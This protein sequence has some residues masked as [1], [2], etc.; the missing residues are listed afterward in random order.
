MGST[1]RTAQILFGIY[2]IK[3]REVCR[4]SSAG[5]SDRRKSIARTNR[6]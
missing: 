3:F 2:K 1:G 5:I 4:K 6:A